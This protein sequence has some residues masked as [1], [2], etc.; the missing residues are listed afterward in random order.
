MDNPSGGLLGPG[1]VAL[2]FP[3]IG[4][5]SAIFLSLPLPLPSS[6]AR[7]L[8]SACS[9]EGNVLIAGIFIL[10]TSD[11]LFVPGGELTPTLKLKRPVV[12][13]KYAT[14]IDAIYN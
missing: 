3:N 4:R 7:D 10:S 9:A 12:Y 1:Y 13:T 14:E 6:C 11:V 8:V 2:H 5:A